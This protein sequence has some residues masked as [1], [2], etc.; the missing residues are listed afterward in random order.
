MKRHRFC[1]H[2]WLKFGLDTCSVSCCLRCGFVYYLE[3]PKKIIDSVNLI[4]T[5]FKAYG[6]KA[7][8]FMELFREH[9][10]TLIK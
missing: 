8:C 9:K 4:S 7:G 6:I 10:A 1:K 5:A 2:K 3:Y